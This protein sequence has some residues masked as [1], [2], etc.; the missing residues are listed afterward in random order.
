VTFA[1]RKVGLKRPRAGADNGGMHLVLQL[2][3]NPLNMYFLAT[4][5]SY[6]VL[7]GSVYGVFRAAWDFATLARGGAL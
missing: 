7:A 3:S 1:P 5:I 4:P 2:G 6:A